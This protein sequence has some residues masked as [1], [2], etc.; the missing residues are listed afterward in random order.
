MRPEAPAFHKVSHTSFS[1]SDA[2]RSAAWCAEVLGLTELE[3][4]H[5]DGWHGI[6]LV[7]RPSGT[8]LEYQQHDS[9]SGESFDPRRTGLDHVGLQVASRADLDAWQRRFADLGVDHTAVV[10]RD[11]GAVL[12]FRDHDGI[13]LEMFFRE[14]HP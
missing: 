11:Y 6:V 7:H 10:D 1:V 4:V 9:N 14:N 12:T 2:E 13:Q 3:R 8:V 5:G